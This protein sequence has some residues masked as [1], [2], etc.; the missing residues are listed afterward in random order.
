M[1]LISRT[2]WAPQREIKYTAQQQELRNEL[3]RTLNKADTLKRD[4]ILDVVQAL[5]KAYP[6]V[7]CIPAIPANFDFGSSS[8]HV[9]TMDLNGKFFTETIE[10]AEPNE[11][12]LD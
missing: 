2:T 1:P 5:E 7:E 11:T 6:F 10:S 12:T 3:Q 9:L 4:L 8:Y